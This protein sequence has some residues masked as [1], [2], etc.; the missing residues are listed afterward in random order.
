MFNIFKVIEKG[1]NLQ[2]IS[3]FYHVI[4]DVQPC[5]VRHAHVP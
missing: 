3:Y 2:E 4:N 5:L 1:I